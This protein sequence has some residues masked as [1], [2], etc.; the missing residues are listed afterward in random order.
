MCL[1]PGA[2]CKQ[3]LLHSTGSQIVPQVT[4]MKGAE[5]IVPPNEVQ[6]E[7]AARESIHW[8]VFTQP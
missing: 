1:Q 3:L 7:R 8:A 2:Y 4:N 6:L 5:C